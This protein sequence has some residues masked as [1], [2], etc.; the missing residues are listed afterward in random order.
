MQAVIAF[1]IHRNRPRLAWLAA[2][3][4]A[5]LLAMLVTSPMPAGAGTAGGDQ[6]PSLT[7]GGATPTPRP[8]GDLGTKVVTGRVFDG[9]R[10][11]AAG[12]AGATIDYVRVAHVP[13]GESGSMATDAAGDF[14]F[15]LF[16]RDTD[17]VSVAVSAPGFR[18]EELAYTGYA[19]WIAPPLEIGLLP[20]R[21]AVE[22]A[23]TS[24]VSLPCE[25][26]GEVAIINSQPAGGDALTV[27]AI[28]P[29]N[30]YSQGDYGTGFSWDLSHLELPLT[31]AP[32][33]R[34]AF[35][36]HYSAAG[37]TF[38][39]RLTVRLRST[40]SDGE[41]F[42]VPYRGEIA[43]CGAPTP[44]PTPT[45]TAPMPPRD[46]EDDGCQVTAA[47]SHSWWALIPL[48]LLIGRRHVARRRV[49]NSCPLLS[50]RY[51]LRSPCR[52]TKMLQISLAQSFYAM[53]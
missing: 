29:S 47:P 23:P 41:G 48:A 2:I 53:R 5:G 10:G 15:Q 40:A 25:G 49:A 44:T 22:I 26:D 50:W 20:L 28:L 33:E 52:L 7:T 32:G 43:D 21:G 14:A 31:L 37:Q 45:A 8:P 36:V 16:L 11:V 46:G 18:S 1:T 30:S 12:L 39:S 27:A 19:L 17:L 24:P 13:P 9:L 51:S 34:V 35:P 38:P 3:C 42:G 4:R 6:L